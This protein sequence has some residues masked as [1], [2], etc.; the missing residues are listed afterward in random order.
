MIIGIIAVAMVFMPFP[1]NNEVLAAD[2]EDK[3]I[4]FAFDSSGSMAGI[5][6]GEEKIDIAR[7]A[8]K[9]VLN[10]LPSNSAS[11]LR[12]FSAHTGTCTDSS[13]DVD[14]TTNSDEI[15]NMVDT[16]EPGGL[17]PIA[18]TLQQSKKDFSNYS[19]QDNLDSKCQSY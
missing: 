3:M 17:T 19:N 5:I 16:Y 10:G 7:D 6:D 2:V 8:L 12:S 11:A 14:F 1:K 18:Y 13:L 9:N 15:K 4:E